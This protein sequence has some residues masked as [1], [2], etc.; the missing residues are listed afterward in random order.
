MIIGVV[1]ADREAVI[2]LE[3]CGQ[4]SQVETVDAVIDT[5]FDGWLSLPPSLIARLGLVWKSRGRALLAN[6]SE[7]IVDMYDGTILWDGQPRRVSVDEAEMT[8]LVG[9]VLLEGM[10]LKVEVRPMGQ[11]TIRPLP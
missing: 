6:G 11:I 2:R 5:G 8:P 3:V 10:E 4:G 7:C 1:P 9:M